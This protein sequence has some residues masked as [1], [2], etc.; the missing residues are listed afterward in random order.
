MVII[1]FDPHK[2]THTASA[3]DPG[4]HRVL[5]TLQIAATLARY[6]QLLRWAQGSS[7]GAGRWKRPRS[8]PAPGAVADRPWRTRRRAVH[9][10]R[11][12][13]ELSRGGRK[14]DVIDAGRSSKR[15]RSGPETPDWSP[16][17]TSRPRWGYSTSG[18]PTSSLTAPGWSTSCT[19]Y[20][21]TSCPAAP[22]PT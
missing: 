9:C 7:R 5:A 19:R 6:R 16:L 22:I 20:C 8:G 10:H 2:R 15:R 17:R 14:N 1:E 3:L 4:T 12:V 11:R 18:A 21:V 13:R